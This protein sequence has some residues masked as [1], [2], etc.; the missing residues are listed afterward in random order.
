MSALI[1]SSN[2]KIMSF[3]VAHSDA[4]PPRRVLHLAWGVPYKSGVYAGKV[5]CLTPGCLHVVQRST[6]AEAIWHDRHA[7]VSRGHSSVGSGSA[8]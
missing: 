6:D 8:I 3:A 2:T 4:A 5:S 7:E 1:K